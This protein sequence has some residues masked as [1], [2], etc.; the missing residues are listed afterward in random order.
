MR[1]EKKHGHEDLKVLGS[2]SRE[3]DVCL[4]SVSGPKTEKSAGA[5]LVNGLLLMTRATQCVPMN[6][7]D[8]GQLTLGFRNQEVVQIIMTARYGGAKSGMIQIPRPNFH[9]IVKYRTMLCLIML[10]LRATNRCNLLTL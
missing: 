2:V 7:E 8:S 6:G 4:G 1:N 9:P 3:S 10:N 5:Y